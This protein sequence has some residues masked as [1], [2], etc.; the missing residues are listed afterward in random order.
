LPPSSSV[1]VSPL[2]P[3][4]LHILWIPSGG[5][6]SADVLKN[7][8]LTLPCRRRMMM[9]SGAKVHYKSMFDAGSQIIAKEGTKSLFKGAGYVLSH[10][11]HRAP[12]AD[13]NV[14]VPT[15]FVVLLV[16]VC[17]RCTTSSKSLC[18]AR[19]VTCATCPHLHG[20]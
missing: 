6:V 16:L 10:C 7:A 17:C 8:S 20:R 19:F 5:H 12:Y 9:T 1:G 14:A 11:D 3:V 18:S 15:S 2:V 13:V 4:L